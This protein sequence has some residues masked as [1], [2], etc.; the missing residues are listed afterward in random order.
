MLI[1]VYFF[2][3]F[4][5][6]AYMLLFFMFVGIESSN[7]TDSESVQVPVSG[8][9]FSS[10]DEVRTF[11]RTY[12]YQ[13]GFGVCKINSRKSGDVQYYT[14]A[15]T[16][17]GHYLSTS[18]HPR[19]TVACNCPARI[20]VKVTQGQYEIS[21]VVLDHNH[22]LTPSAS[23][24]FRSHKNLDLHSRRTLEI[25]DAA[26]VRMNQS[27]STLVHEA[28]GHEQM[29]FNQSEARTYIRKTRLQLEAGDAE[30]L[31][32]Y[33]TDMTLKNSDF[34]YVLDL[35]EDHRLRN[36][37]WADARSRAAYES[38]SDVIT[39][40]STYLTNKYD[41]PFAPFVGVNHHG[42]SILLGCA[43][44]SS[45]TTDTYTWLFRTWLRCMG[46]SSP[47]GIVTDQCESMRKA[48]STV[49]PGTRHRL[50]LW[51]IMQKIPTK[52]GANSNYKMIKK[53]LKTLV[54]E[55]V[56][57][58]EFEMGWQEM[59]L[60]FGLER[61]E[62]LCSLYDIR[63]SWVSVYLKNHFWAGMSTT[64]R[65][66][67]MNTF[68]DG[69]VNSKTTLRQFVVRRTICTSLFNLMFTSL[70]NIIFNV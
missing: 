7:N 17:H 67:S 43:L 23:H 4:N 56:R 26:G 15:C 1:L 6:Y 22:E 70:F 18:A 8:L 13:M 46:G 62:W 42:Q 49:F 20:N 9:I 38:F 2:R 52:L 32:Q 3:T 39:F 51:H 55:S 45:E 68:F 34:F 31:Q 47:G 40:D 21:K 29:T 36:V 65:S 64:Q 24:R 59:V 60:K 27:Y 28:G 66:E 14:L 50:C 10:E 54:Y 35:D 61:N 16:R 58:V 5:C 63:T 41:M 25:N 69:Y 12:S 33:F 48:I 44:L 30:A 11:Y 57:E 53:S 37:F 19:P